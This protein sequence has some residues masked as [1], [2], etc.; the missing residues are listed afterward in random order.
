MLITEGVST[1]SIAPGKANFHIDSTNIRM[2]RPCKRR[3][4]SKNV[5]ADQELQRRRA[6]NDLRLKS[7]FELI[8]EKY[9]KDFTGIGD[10]IDLE[11]GEIVVNHG[12]VSTMKNEK[13]PGRVEDLYDELEGEN[14][15][16]EDNG[17]REQDHVRQRN[18]L[19][20]SQNP[21][22]NP[23]TTARVIEDSWDSADEPDSL[24]GDNRTG[25]STDAAEERLKQHAKIKPGGHAH[26][27][28]EP[29]PLKAQDLCDLRQ[30]ESRPAPSAHSINYPEEAVDNQ[31]GVELLWR[32]PPL[33]SKRAAH[34]ENLSPPNLHIPDACEDRPMSPPGR[35]LWA[36]QSSSVRG[37]K[38]QL[39]SK[40]EDRL[41]PLSDRSGVPLSAIE[42]TRS[43]RNMQSLSYEW[44]KICVNKSLSQGPTFLASVTPQVSPNI[45]KVIGRLPWTQ[46][47]DH[48]LQYLKSEAGVSYSQMTTSFPGRSETEIEDRWLF[49]YLAHNSFPC[50]GANYQEYQGD[51]PNY[52][53]RAS[54]IADWGK[55]GSKNQRPLIAEQI[56]STSAGEQQLLVHDMGEEA[57]EPLQS[58]H[59]K[60][61]SSTDK[62]GYFGGDETRDLGVTMEKVVDSKSLAG[63]KGTITAGFRDPPENPEP[64]SEGDEDSGECGQQVLEGKPPE[65][66]ATNT[67]KKRPR[68]DTKSTVGVDGNDVP[69]P[70]EVAESD[71]KASPEILLQQKLLR[72]G[73]RKKKPTLRAGRRKLIAVNR[74]VAKLRSQAPSSTMKPATLLLTHGLPPPPAAK[75]LSNKPKE[76]EV[77]KTNSD[78][79]PKEIKND[80][81]RT[82]RPRPSK[83]YSAGA[84]IQPSDS[85]SACSP[86]KPSPD[87]EKKNSE[88]SCTKCSATVTEGAG[89]LKGEL[90]C[91]L[92]L[93]PVS[94]RPCSLKPPASTP[95]T[96]HEKVI[97]PSSSS[98]TSIRRRG[99]LDDMQDILESQPLR[100]IRISQGR[101]QKQKPPRAL[102]QTRT[103][104]RV[105]DHE[106]NPT[107][108]IVSDDLSD[109]ELS[110]PIQRT[111]KI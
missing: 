75:R 76:L 6:C 17:R 73:C 86:T 97:V 71:N 102:C 53:L 91:K 54:N 8:F 48:K 96:A 25:V 105:L 55:G 101:P 95:K 67:A 99:D 92:C 89:F 14:W 50:V 58:P 45:C 11:T 37:K 31:D 104:R 90:H 100:S 38:H 41:Q 107:H 82:L 68:P 1:F 64:K 106:P 84:K 20:T 65:P 70:I 52:S 59:I 46:Y 40:R 4:I 111:P 12:H 47:E 30:N 27:V 94:R 62:E 32:A 13:D 77:D 109:D 5:V 23:P 34:N 60:T 78:S 57:I 39:A 44:S 69:F 93:S 63:E 103:K 98:P 43:R 33:P 35:S 9:G 16:T 19:A 88:K 42:R 51:E 80:T 81:P 26:L 56:P 66:V 72:R 108:A 83:K 15:L 28:R 61:R 10:E 36:P 87:S 24:M 74:E 18:M 7:A 110:M 85:I 21:P 22:N 2:E 49:L 79:P 3:R 29:F